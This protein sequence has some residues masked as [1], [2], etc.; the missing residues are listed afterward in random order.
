M[1]WSFPDGRC[2]RRNASNHGVELARPTSVGQSSNS[3]SNP[4]LAIADARVGHP[5]ATTV[6]GTF[7]FAAAAA[8][9]SAGPDPNR[10]V[11]VAVDMPL[12]A[13]DATYEDAAPSR[14]DLLQRAAELGPRM[15]W[16]SI[17]F[18]PTD[19]VLGEKMLPRV[20]ERRARF[21]KLVK[22]ALGACVAFCMVATAASAIST[23]NSSSE[24]SGSSSVRTAPA[25]RIASIEKLEVPIVTKGAATKA[26][27]KA[28]TASRPGPAPKHGKRR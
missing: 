4:F 21:R 28:T 9:S 16:E 24:A 14:Q 2:L 20:A 17:A 22:V 7:P 23:T 26:S 18:Q 6:P 5:F 3:N 13:D 1:S 15:T 10:A 11:D 19:P 12:S 27:S 25:T 8:A